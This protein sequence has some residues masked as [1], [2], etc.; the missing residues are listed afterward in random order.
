M[1]N[2]LSEIIVITDR[3]SSMS[4]VRDEA[5]KGFNGFLKE[6]QEAD[7]GKC[8]LTYCQFNTEY[9]IVHNGIP[10]EAMKP[11]DHRTYQPAGMTALLD[12][13]GRTIDAVGDRLAK[14]P[15]SK[16]PGS[17]TVVILTDGEENSSEEYDL[18]KV[19]AMIEHQA[20]VYKWTFVFLGKGLDA[21]H[22]GERFVNAD[23]P[24]MFIGQVSD[25][26]DGQ[27]HAYFAASAAVLGNRSKALR[28]VQASFSV[29]EKAAYTSALTGDHD[30]ADAIKNDSSS[31]GS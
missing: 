10:I 14:T 16:R 20:D 8:L 11:L 31:T 12:A 29:Q 1:D 23:H 28:G 30:D 13:V 15:E 4:S 22:G 18:D 26:P 19:K 7:L 3:S 21:F 27:Q 6:Q 9:E 25:N 5:I 2:N 24:Q 17:I